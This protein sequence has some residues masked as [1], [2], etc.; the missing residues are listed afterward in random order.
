MDAIPSR[1]TGVVVGPVRAVMLVVE[2]QWTWYRR[3]WRSTA[4]SSFLQPVLFLLAMGFGFGSQV[5]PGAVTGGHSYLVYLAPALLVVT[6]VQNATWEST[7]P[8][9]SSFIW[10]KSYWGAVVTPVTPAQIFYAQLTWI[11]LRLVSSALVYVAVAAALGAVGGPGVLLAVPF[12]VL[13]GLAFAAPVVAFSA[14]RD[15]AEGFTGLF[16]FVVIP[17]TLFTGAFFPI[18][19]LPGWLR[20]VAW[21]TPMWHGVE[22]A[23]GAAFGT[24]RLVPALG[25]IGYLLVMGA[26]GVVLGRKYFRRRLA[27]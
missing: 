20:P 23:R 8:V 27:V 12:A 16:R 22:L 19:Q 3:N 18:T 9:L 24:L 13:A 11:G 10:Q 21:V 5:Q 6:T 2:K 14:T 26:V 7:Y 25:H 4:I 15:G 1:S 17:M